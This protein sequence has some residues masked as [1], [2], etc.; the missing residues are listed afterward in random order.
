MSDHPTHRCPSCHAP[1][2]DNHT[3][4]CGPC[5]TITQT[6]LDAAPVLSA[7]FWE[8]PEIRA[9]LLSRHFGRFL[10]AYR[11]TQSPQVK[12]TQ[13]A[14]WL[15]V[16]QSQL[17]RIERSATPIHDLHKLDT[18]AR[19][20]HI[21]AD[22][23]WFSPSPASSGTDDAAPDR[24]TVEKSPHSEEGSGVR[25]RNL[26]QA[27]GVGVAAAATGAGLLS[28]TP[29]QR[30]I[31]SV[32]KGRPADTATVQLM[33]DRT[34]D[35]FH[36]EETVPA[37]QLLE[38]IAQHRNTLEALLA[39]SRTESLQRDLTVAMGETDVL[40]GW[41]LFDLGRAHDAT[42]AWRS[43][44][45]IA[46]ETGDGA[47]A[48]C[49]L[50]YWSYLAASRNDTAPAARL[51]QQAKEYVPGASAPATRSWLAAREAEELARLG[52]ETGALRAVERA[53]TAFDFARPRSERPWTA[54][55]SASRLGSMTVSAYTTLH[56][57]DAAAVADSLL[58]S[59][60][61]MENKVRAIVLSDLTINAAQTNDYDRAITLIPDAI[62]LTTRTETTL[63]KQRLLAL[64]TT[65][66]PMSTTHPSSVLRDQI[67]STLRR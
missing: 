58:I 26:F 16:T 52:D 32:S 27:A 15:G 63:A 23:L 44:L 29:W 22:R 1:A 35:L 47:L 59:L 3:G 13:L 6:M 45:K 67:M 53:L 61:P 60:S 11:T 49:T 39:N 28:D 21:P 17:S 40:T 62:E 10:R 57:R 30:L 25:R 46:K 41:L 19:A 65:L 36:T 66:R 8:Q 37:R 56:H 9:A 14:Y 55:F 2:T 54:F 64:A 24:A 4:L 20:L 7:D 5:A 12:Q 33:Q 48:A 31:D 34:A 38:T 51:L 18:W 50:G 42:N 43:T